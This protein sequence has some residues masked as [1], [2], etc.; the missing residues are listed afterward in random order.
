[1]LLFLI[2]SISNESISNCTRS[3]VLDQVYIIV[4]W[5]IGKYFKYVQF[6]TFQN[7]QSASKSIYN[8]RKLQ[9]NVE[10]FVW[11]WDLDKVLTIMPHSLPSFSRA[12][13][14]IM[15]VRSC[16]NFPSWKLLLTRKRFSLT[17]TSRKASPRS[18]RPSRLKL[19]WHLLVVIASSIC[20]TW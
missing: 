3:A 10:N 5:M 1:M 7:R 4:D 13:L 9:S 6:L 20:S 16:D 15:D 17:A 12:E 18:S 2:E 8:S 14:H 11:Q 19:S